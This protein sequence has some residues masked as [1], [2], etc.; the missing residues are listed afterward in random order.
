[1]KKL[2]ILI[3]I[4][5]SNIA[6]SHQ[7]EI[8]CDVTASQLTLLSKIYINVD[9][10]NSKW[11]KLIVGENGKPLKFNSVIDALNFMAEDG[12]HLINTLLITHQNQQVYHYIMAKKI[13]K[14][15]NLNDKKSETDDKDILINEYY[16]TKKGV[17]YIKKTLNNFSKDS[18]EYRDLSAKKDEFERK[19]D[20]LYKEYYEK[21]N[22]YIE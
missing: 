18:K 2:F 5:I 10:G 8:Y 4:S 22:I 16:K 14:E 17:K 20:A 13:D 9:F 19:L 11:G 6:Y 3:F 21:Y 7:K 1:M 12:W 15:I